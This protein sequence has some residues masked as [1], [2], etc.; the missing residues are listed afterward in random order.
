MSLEQ[1]KRIRSRR[2]EQR[3]I[4]LQEQRRIL[5]AQELLIRSKE[6][7]LAEFA[8]WRLQHQETLFANLKNQPFAPQALFDY[9]KTLEQL[10]LQEEH[11]Q[12]ELA[13]TY[14]GLQTAESQVQLAQQKSSEA[15]LKLE[16]LKEIINLQDVKNSSE[17]PAQ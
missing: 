15:N 3:F 8:Q 16:K 1:L 17:E 14:K 12:A 9:Q 7:E 4:E 11:L 2:M 6:R 5:A 13:A 10:R